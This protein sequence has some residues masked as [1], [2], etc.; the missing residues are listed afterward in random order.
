MR[1]KVLLLA[2]TVALA[3]L[4]VAGAAHA[5]H[6]RG[7][8]LQFRCTVLGVKSIDPILDPVP[9]HAHSHVFTGNRSVNASSTHKSLKANTSGTTCRRPSAPSGGQWRAANSSYWVPRLRDDQQLPVKFMTIYYVDS[10]EDRGLR[11][12]PENTNLIG[13]AS[14]GDID[15]RCGAGAIVQRPPYGCKSEFRAR[16]LFPNCW[17][18]KNASNPNNWIRKP[19]CPSTHPYETPALRIA[20]H[21]RK[22][23]D[24]VLNSP[25]R[26]ST[27][28]GTWGDWT[29]FHADKMDA[30]LNPPR[31]PSPGFDQM[32]HACVIDLGPST[33]RPDSCGPD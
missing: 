4:Y 12:F 32:L 17:N 13:S 33:P 6:S 14:R 5:T 29:T 9:E 2:V 24:G 15:F 3:A 21:Y 31:V 30:D 23:A 22:P 19:D 25:L 10:S 28:A 7:A 26:V 8:E 27:G 16:V 11:K 1:R 18:Q 20:T